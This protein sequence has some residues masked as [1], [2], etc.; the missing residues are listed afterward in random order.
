[1]G[2]LISHCSFSLLVS[3]EQAEKGVHLTLV[4]GPTWNR[5]R[6]EMR[7]SLE[8]MAIPGGGMMFHEHL[9]L[10]EDCLY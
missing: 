7:L 6:K 5:G 10:Q 8:S 1:M 3:R 2:T 4:L 9:L